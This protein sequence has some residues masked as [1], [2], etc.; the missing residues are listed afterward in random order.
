MDQLTNS[1]L[2][3]LGG[4]RRKFHAHPEVSGDECR[5]GTRISQA[6]TTIGA[7]AILPACP[8]D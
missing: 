6:L 3:V 1:D 7:D 5:T 8:Q 2:A 4:L